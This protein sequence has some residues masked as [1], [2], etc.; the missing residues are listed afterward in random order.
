MT[1]EQ[2][3]E[4][5]ELDQIIRRLDVIINLM[6]KEAKG[7]EKIKILNQIGLKA[8]E[9]AGVMGRTRSYVDSELTQIRKE[10]KKK[11]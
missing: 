6:L 10:L 2:K 8:N 9:I 7:R 3:K 5:M 11:K 1:K 4:N